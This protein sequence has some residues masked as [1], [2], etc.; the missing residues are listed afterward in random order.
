MNSMNAVSA[1]D[2]SKY[3]KLQDDLKIRDAQNAELC[4]L[5]E[6]LEAKNKELAKMNNELS[7]R[8]RSMTDSIER[9]EHEATV[10]YAQ[11]DIVRLI[12]GGNS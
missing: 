10:L 4:A 6:H 3:F 7:E 9:M 12:F 8:V 5:V 2:A 11:L 1:V